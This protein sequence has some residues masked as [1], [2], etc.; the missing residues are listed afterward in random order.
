VRPHVGI[1]AGFEVDRSEV[2]QEHEGADGAARQGGKQ[3]AHAQATTQIFVVAGKFE[4]HFSVSPQS[5]GQCTI[6]A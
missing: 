3:T 6:R 1:H 4:Q 5:D 2:I